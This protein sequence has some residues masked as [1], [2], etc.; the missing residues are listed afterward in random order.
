MP[1]PSTASTSVREPLW[2]AA[3][4]DVDAGESGLNEVDVDRPLEDTVERGGSSSCD[5]HHKHNTH[6]LGKQ[7]HKHA[8]AHDRPWQR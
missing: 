6:E 8:H 3:S 4:G 1:S 2:R 7:A 5:P